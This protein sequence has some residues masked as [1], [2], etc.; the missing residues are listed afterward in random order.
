MTVFKIYKLQLNMK[1]L[2]HE[3][4]LSYETSNFLLPLILIKLFNKEAILPENTEYF[5][6]NF[7]TTLP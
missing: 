2:S 7:E 5:T 1:H 3:S 6:Y 4:S